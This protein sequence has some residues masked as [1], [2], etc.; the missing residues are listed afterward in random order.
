LFPV[1]D[2]DWSYNEYDWDGIAYA[3]CNSYVEEIQMALDTN[4]R[5]F[6]VVNAEHLKIVLLLTHILSNENA[7]F[8]LEFLT[9][10]CVQ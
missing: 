2:F 6:V 1:L 8:T 7:S 9:V 10:E 4:K 3:L 5:F